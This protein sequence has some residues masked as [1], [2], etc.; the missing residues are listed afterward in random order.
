MLKNTL[1]TQITLFYIFKYNNKTR[2]E[3]TPIHSLMFPDM[4][5]ITC[6][7]WIWAF[8]CTQFF[9]MS[10]SAQ[11]VFSYLQV[12]RQKY[13]KKMAWNND[14]PKQIVYRAKLNPINR[15]SLWQEK[16]LLELGFILTHFIAVCMFKKRKTDPFE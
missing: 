15:H 11:T 4:D 9:A 8:G 7:F 10:R 5:K 12:S 16:Q 2:E 14:P 1:I 3:E 6:F 13:S